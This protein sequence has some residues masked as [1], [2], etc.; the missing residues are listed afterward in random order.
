MFASWMRQVGT[1]SHLKITTNPGVPLMEQRGIILGVT[2][3]E[4]GILGRM[5]HTSVKQGW[6]EFQLTPPGLQPPS[7]SPP[8]SAG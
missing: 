6:P 2:R 4:Q 5:D 1:G 3:S 8:S 7:L